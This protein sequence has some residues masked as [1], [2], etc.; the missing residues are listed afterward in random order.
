MR[1]GLVLLL[2]WFVAGLLAA[3]ALGP[4]LADCDRRPE[5]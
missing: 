3:L 1:T 5:P 4:F 2:V